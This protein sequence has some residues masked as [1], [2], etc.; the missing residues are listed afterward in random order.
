MSELNRNIEVIIPGKLAAVKFSYI[1][2]IPE[3]EY[4][5]DPDIPAYTEYCRITDGGVFLLNKDSPGYELLKGIVRK[6]IRLPLHRL[7]REQGKTI[8]LITHNRELALETDRYVT[9]RDGR[10]YVGD[11]GEEVRYGA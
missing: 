9:M 10:L 3:I 2:F 7:N 5:P 11:T 4:T 1:P 8:V 6:V